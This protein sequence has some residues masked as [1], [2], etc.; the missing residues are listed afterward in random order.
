MPLRI[1]LYAP[2][3]HEENGTFKKYTHLVLKTGSPDYH[4]H[5]NS[6]STTSDQEV[7]YAQ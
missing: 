5:F 3:L 7:W 2:H 6:K 4:D 1:I